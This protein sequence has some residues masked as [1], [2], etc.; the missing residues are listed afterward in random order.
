MR[1]STTTRRLSALLALVVALL[2][3]LVLVVG[4]PL[5]ASA[6]TGTVKGQVIG[7]QAGPLKIRMMWFDRHWTY[8]G[9]RRLDRDIY[10]LSLPAGTYHLQFVDLRPSYDVTKY[11]PSDVTVTVSAGNPVQRDVKMRRGAALTGTVKAGGRPARGARVVAASTD[12]T[13]YETTANRAG[14]FA[15]GGLPAGDY[16]VFTYDRQKTWVARSTWVPKLQRPEVR[17]LALTMRAKGGSML[18]DLKRPDGKAMKGSFFVTAVSRASGQFWTE[19]AQRGTVIFQG[20]YP[21]RYR[22]VAPGVGIY[23]ARTG[24]VQGGNVRPGRADLVSRFAWTRRGAWLTG[25]VVDKEAPDVPLEGAQVLLYD[26]AGNQIGG[27]S[28]NEQ[29][30]YTLKGQLSTQ[31]GLTVAVQPDPDRDGWLQGENYCRFERLEVS[32]V[33][34]RTGHATDIGEVLLPHQ[35]SSDRLCAPAS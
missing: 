13:S 35:P 17:N 20:L 9:Q 6:E 2:A 33:A 15:L 10:S 34:I 27:T 24:S 19:R 23:L 12:E 25:S 5:P 29:G 18:V 8:L 28:T 3:S 31:A 7:T 4:S 14:Q 11:A 1:S 30:R 21:G 22:M 32:P 26:K 16:S